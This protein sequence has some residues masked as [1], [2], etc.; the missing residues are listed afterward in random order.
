MDSIQFFP[1]LRII[2]LD[3]FPMVLNGNFDVHRLPTVSQQRQL[4]S[5]CDFEKKTTMLLPTPVFV[6]WKHIVKICMIGMS[7][8]E[9]VGLH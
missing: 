2:N 5:Y 1:G 4:I 8:N 9:N 3:W 7:S 6:S